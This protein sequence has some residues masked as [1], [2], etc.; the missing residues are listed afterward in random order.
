MRLAA[1]LALAI[2]LAAFP[3]SASAAL[4]VSAP[5]LVPVLNQS[6]YV[7]Y[8]VYATAT[9]Q[10]E[11]DRSEGAIV[12]YNAAS[13]TTKGIRFTR[14]YRTKTKTLN[15]PHR[16]RPSLVFLA[17][18]TYSVTVHWLAGGG[19]CGTCDEAG[20]SPPTVVTVPAQIPRAA[21]IWTGSWRTRSARR[22]SR[23]G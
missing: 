17:G 8:E 10:Y 22:F 23:T 13:D 4:Q 7:T 21:W 2:A 16:P 3:S 14:D 9:G 1:G 5:T 15:L 18:E 6:G 12:S 19:G 11:H 20:V